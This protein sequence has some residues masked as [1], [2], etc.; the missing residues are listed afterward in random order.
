MRRDHDR[1]SPVRKPASMKSTRAF[2]EQT[3]V[4]VDPHQVLAGRD[5][6]LEAR[7]TG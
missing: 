1:G 7:R 5:L 6:T 2:H 4:L 3:F